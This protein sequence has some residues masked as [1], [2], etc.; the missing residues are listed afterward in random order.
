MVSERVKAHLGLVAA[1]LVLAV[2]FSSIIAGAVY[3]GDLRA[4]LPGS[5]APDF[6]LRDA[7][8][9]PVE[10]ADL[11][12]DVV[13]VYFRGT[14]GERPNIG[15]ATAPSDSIASRRDSRAQPANHAAATATSAQSPDAP[16]VEQLSLMCHKLHNSHLKVL[17][18]EEHAALATPDA[19]VLSLNSPDPSVRTLI[20]RTG[21]VARRFKIDQGDSKP[22]FFVIDPAGIIRYRGNDLSGGGAAP[23]DQL[24]LPATQPSSCPQIVQ[25]LLSSEALSVQ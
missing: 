8:N 3:K 24:P 20:D 10:L 7:D 1:V 18:L 19:A 14:S 15:A 2:C 6:S 4:G 16:A 9:S 21:D 17:D 5:V 25:T 12:G 13:I 23:E 11:R 22:T